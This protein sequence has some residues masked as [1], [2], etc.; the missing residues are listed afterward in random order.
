MA[1][2]KRTSASAKTD[3]VFVNRFRKR[4]AFSATAT[5]VNCHTFDTF[6]NISKAAGHRQKWILL[7]GFIRPNGQAL[8]DSPTLNSA[9]VNMVCQLCVGEQTAMLESD[10]PEVIC[11][12]HMQFTNNT[13][14]GQTVNWPVPFDLVH[15]FP[16]LARQI[17]FNLIGSTTYNGEEFYVELHFVGANVQGSDEAF[18]M[19]EATGQ[20]TG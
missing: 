7:G 4:I 5:T 3:D 11:E 15:P 1:K 16:L 12:A 20:I 10:D 14:G 8:A 6:M 2:R 19:L 18:E 9:E 17:T 13:S